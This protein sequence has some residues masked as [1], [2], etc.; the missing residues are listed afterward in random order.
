M[1]K[2]MKILV[3]RLLDAAINR[4]REAVRVIED[5]VRFVYD[6]KESTAELKSF[7]HDFS[8]L[9][10]QFSWSERLAA[11]ETEH[12]VGTSLQGKGESDRQSLE[13][14]LNANFCRLQ[15]ALRSLEEITKLENPELSSQYKALRYRAYI[16]HKK[17][18]DHC[19]SA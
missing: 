7:R 13:A 6:N 10:Q 12:D 9:T 18:G 16:L 5:V 4:A 14:V 11:R 8:I 19:H 1:E 15:E 2:Q 17:I 3:W